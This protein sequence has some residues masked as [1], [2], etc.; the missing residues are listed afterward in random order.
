MTYLH[1][2]KRLVGSPVKYT[3]GPASVPLVLAVLLYYPSRRPAPPSSSARS[4]RTRTYR[5]IPTP[6]YTAHY[7]YK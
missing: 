2:V 5:R 7:I 6:A 3:L 1:Y 4:R